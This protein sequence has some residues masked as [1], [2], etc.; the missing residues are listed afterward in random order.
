MGMGEW[1]E[2]DNFDVEMNYWFYDTFFRFKLNQNNNEISFGFND[3]SFTGYFENVDNM[4]IDSKKT[5]VEQAIKETDAIS[6]NKEKKLRNEGIFNNLKANLIKL[7][8]PNL[9]KE[10]IWYNRTDRDHSYDSL[11]HSFGNRKITF[12]ADKYH[13]TIK[14]NNNLIKTNPLNESPYNSVDF[15]KSVNSSINNFENIKDF[16]LKDISDFIHKQFDPQSYDYFLKRPLAEKIVQTERREIDEYLS[17]DYE[18]IEHFYEL[19]VNNKIHEWD[20]LSY[21]EVVVLLKNKE[22]QA[23]MSIK[24]NGLYPDPESLTL[25]P[26]QESQK[27]ENAKKIGYVQGVCECVKI[28]GDDHALGKKLLSEMKVTKDMAKKYAYPE[29]YKEL[30][31]GIFAPQ[32]EQKLE[33]KQGL[34]R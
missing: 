1:K 30:E 20:N 4:D 33:Q 23:V 14:E 18:Y 15:E 7:D 17:D 27:L 24:D 28:V 5:L 8:N 22:N 13:F 6:Y 21:D 34:R 19:D 12:I 2:Y 9:L 29:T 11:I 31:K 25:N 3:K 26:K 32:Q 10:D 16:S